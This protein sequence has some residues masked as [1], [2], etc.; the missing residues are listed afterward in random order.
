MINLRRVDIQAKVAFFAAI[1]SI[2]VTVALAY[3]ALKGLQWDTKIIPYSSKSNRMLGVLGS[4]ATALGIGVIG[5]WFGLISAGQRRNEQQVL[6]WLGFFLSAMT[7][8][9]SAILLTT[10]MLWRE[11]VI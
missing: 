1:L 11:S 4:G 5:F 9:A 8:T 3:F 6:S 7:I 2:M 10:F